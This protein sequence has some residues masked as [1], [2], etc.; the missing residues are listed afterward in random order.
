MPDTST[1][2]AYALETRAEK[3]T[4]HTADVRVREGETDRVEVGRSE[5]SDV[6][7]GSESIRVGGRLKEEYGQSQ[8]VRARRLETTVEGSL[9]MKGHSHSTILGGAMSETHTGGVFVAA[10]MSDDMVI[11]GGMRVTVPADIW[12]TYLTGMEEKLLTGVA[13]GIFLE[14]YGTHFERDY[15]TSM[16]SAAVAV[17]TGTIC[18]TTATGFRQLSHVATHVR[19]LVPGGGGGG[20]EGP[21]AGAPP[22]PPPAPPAVAGSLVGGATSAGG[23]VGGAAGA[24]RAANLAPVFDQAQN[25]ARSVDTARDVQNLQ[26]LTGAAESVGGAVEEGVGVGAR[27]EELSGL[28]GRPDALDSLRRGL[29]AVDE[30]DESETLVD[31]MTL[32]VKA[33]N[34]DQDARAGLMRMAGAGD[35]NARQ[36]LSTLTGVSGE[37]GGVL[38]LRA[39]A[40]GGDQDALDELRRI[41]AAEGSTAEDARAG[42]LYSD[43]PVELRNIAAY[44]VVDARARLKA[45]ADGGNAEAAAEY[46]K[47]LAFEEAV[48]RAEEASSAVDTEL[49]LASTVG[50]L[51]AQTLADRT[52]SSWYAHILLR[53]VREDTLK[54]FLD[55]FSEAA[56]TPPGASVA[57]VRAGLIQGIVN[58]GEAGGVEAATELARTLDLFDSGV[59]EIVDTGLA[60]AE[61]VRTPSPLPAHFDR[62]E[63]I[64]ALQD[65]RA[66]AE[67]R[68]ERQRLVDQGLDDLGLGGGPAVDPIESMYAQAD[69]L[70]FYDKAILNLQDGLDPETELGGEIAFVRWEVQRGDVDSASPERAGQQVANY[71]Q[72]RREIYKIMRKTGGVDGFP[73]REVSGQ[74]SVLSRALASLRAL[75]QRLRD[76]VSSALRRL[77]GLGGSAGG[78]PA[79]VLRGVDD[80]VDT[81]QQGAAGRF[82]PDPDGAEA[83]E[84][85][86]R[87]EDLTGSGEVVPAGA[88]P[89]GGGGPG[90]GL[91]PDPDDGLDLKGYSYPNPD[92]GSGSKSR[93]Q[94]GFSMDPDVDDVDVPTGLGAGEE[95]PRPQRGRK[96]TAAGGNPLK[97]RRRVRVDPGDVPSP[98]PASGPPPAP[99]GPPPAPGTRRPGGI[100]LAP[101]AD[102][103]VPTPGMGTGLETTD[104]EWAQIQKTGPLNRIG[105]DFLDDME[106]M[107]GSA[108]ATILR[109]LEPDPRGANV[110]EI[111]EANTGVKRS[112]EDL[113]DG[114]TFQFG[115]G[116]I[117]P[118]VDLRGRSRWRGKKKKVTYNKQM[119]S[120][121]YDVPEWRVTFSDR[122]EVVFP[123]RGPEVRGGADPDVPTV[124]T[125]LGRF[126]ELPARDSFRKGERVSVATAT[127]DL[128]GATLAKDGS[129]PTQRLQDLLEPVLRGEEAD[130]YFGYRTASDV[131]LSH[132]D[133]VIWHKPK[134]RRMAPKKET[135]AHPVAMDLT[136]HKHFIARLGAGADGLGA[137]DARQAKAMLEDLRKYADGGTARPTG[138][139]Y[140]EDV[141]KRLLATQAGELGPG[142]EINTGSVW[143][144]PSRGDPPTEKMTDAERIELKD[145]FNR[146]RRKGYMDHGGLK[147][148]Y[149]RPS[150]P[151]YQYD[152][153]ETQYFNSQRRW[154]REFD[155]GTSPGKSGFYTSLMQQRAGGL[156]DDHPPTPP[157]GGTATPPP[158]GTAT[159]PPGG[160][161]TP[162]PGGTATPPP[163]GTATPPPGGTAT[164]PPGGTATPPPG[165]TATPPPGGTAT[166]PPANQGSKWP[167]HTPDRASQRATMS[168]SPPGSYPVPR[169][170]G[171]PPRYEPHWRVGDGSEWTA[172]PQDQAEYWFRED[173]RMG[174]GKNY[175]TTRRSP[176]ALPPGQAFYKERQGLSSNCGKHAL[177]TYFGAPVL[178][179]GDEFRRL[180]VEY[181]MT[182]MGLTARQVRDMKLGSGTDPMVL[183][184]IIDK[185]V[186]QG[187]IGPAW[188]RNFQINTPAGPPL[189]AGAD[190][191][192]AAYQR[193]VEHVDSF[194][195]DRV[196]VGYSGGS[197]A[198]YTTLRRHTDGTWQLLDGKHNRAWVYQNLS[199]YLSD[200]GTM[201]IVVMHQEPGFDFQRHARRRGGTFGM[202]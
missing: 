79:D 149:L 121:T 89:G 117:D 21:P 10:G 58:A 151:K 158:G 45:L 157:P 162:P 92:D 141:L 13:D 170:N 160:T 51:D 56:G 17:F 173:A 88:A 76:A 115:G 14:L 116:P 24:G 11:G 195:G 143:H 186:G 167:L 40:D 26:Q 99:S 15:E 61:N 148:G 84:D 30:A 70:A 82:V 22:A 176:D 123:A 198:H 133:E 106:V 18:T 49:F 150:R 118:D 175:Y 199:G 112:A 39:L 81:L 37:D 93:R 169:R 68:F 180:D 60:E 161:A 201:N 91:V 8:M 105:H 156:L 135:I 55:G 74:G 78:A 47:L 66:K 197:M 113:G 196:M 174:R 80:P 67:Q 35:P 140:S 36:Y 28:A 144:W 145:A 4:L 75:Y 44:G 5:S 168:G 85:L 108:Y 96:G 46:R 72:A 119:K 202:S 71:E 127:G 183:K 3:L 98:P 178:T 182:E 16:H 77:R 147:P 50:R 25:V 87:M 136:L 165:G 164:P 132:W 43:D 103:Y 38:M 27:L 83:A 54:P 159:P 23:L 153:T 124:Q 48:A 109:S 192:P 42:R 9:A 69:T 171:E 166:P 20:A 6:V 184:Y 12:V 181:Y 126:E 191:D 137:D 134:N 130:A 101:N 142:D 155:K 41:A 187:Q 111:T 32:Y 90:G 97:N 31:A 1:G 29:D 188:S 172:S 122:S 194:P 2:T 110:E 63:A 34:G 138:A 125:P 52:S 163:G 114:K 53:N 64:R 107:Q 200:H 33:R 65:A 19:N 102:D 146:G 152:G 193:W 94:V 62:D 185:K 95:A 128:H 59:R 7:R 139:S 179:E 120:D 73:P 86:A 154:P 177:N 104:T 189:R 131:E 57:D 129:L 190:A 100:L